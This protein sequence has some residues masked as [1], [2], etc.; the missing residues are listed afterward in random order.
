[1]KNK[2]IQGT[3]NRSLNRPY[4]DTVK[5]WVL[6]RPQPKNAAAETAVKVTTP[7]KMKEGW[8]M[9]QLI[10]LDRDLKWLQG[11]ITGDLKQLGTITH[12]YKVFEGEGLGDFQ[13]SYLG[14]LRFLI[15]CGSKKKALK[16][17]DQRSAWFLNWFEWVSVWNTNIGATSRV[18]WLNIE[19]LPIEAWNDDLF[20]KLA[21]GW[22]RCC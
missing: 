5:R 16:L 13:I 22:G 14:G 3:S 12:I 8:V 15:D 11:C 2:H 18:I 10:P 17:L 1:M 7:P 6:K 21:S 19:G 4:V 20:I 9:V